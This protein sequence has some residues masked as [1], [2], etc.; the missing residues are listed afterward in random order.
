MEAESISKDH[1]PTQDKLKSIILNY[2]AKNRQRV[3]AVLKKFSNSKVLETML[4]IVEENPCEIYYICSMLTTLGPICQTNLT[5]EELVRAISTRDSVNISHFIQVLLHDGIIAADKLPEDLA[6]RK[7]T[8]FDCWN[9]KTYEHTG[10][11][12]LLYYKEKLKQYKEIV[13]NLRPKEAKLLPGSPKREPLPIIIPD[14]QHLV[15]NKLNFPDSDSLRAKVVE[16]MQAKQTGKVLSQDN[17]YLLKH[18]STTL[19]LLDGKCLD[20]LN[21]CI[22]LYSTTEIKR[23]IKPLKDELTHTINNIDEIHKVIDLVYPNLGPGEPMYATLAGDAAQVYDMKKSINLY[24]FELLP[25][26]SNFPVTPIHFKLLPKGSAPASIKKLYTDIISILEA[27]NIKVLFIATDGE[28]ALDTV[29][30]EFFDKYIKSILNQEFEKIIEAISSEEY[31]PLSDMLHLLK[32]ARAHLLNHRLYVDPSNLICV[33]KA[34]MDE[35]LEFSKCLTDTSREGKMK[36]GY[37]IELFSW[38]TLVELYLH[39]RNEAAFFELPNVIAIN[40]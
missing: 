2:T 27:K 31:I 4:D 15:F 30:N 20:V 7:C 17:A 5:V 18:I 37:A 35:A 32:N 1:P 25:L 28:K 12:N 36:D 29:H 9:S 6:I 22:P 10:A 34:L 40:R 13:R 8:H 39:G 16:C 3:S 26:S 33:N 21:G 19:S 38:K 23:F 24:C 11:K 14:E